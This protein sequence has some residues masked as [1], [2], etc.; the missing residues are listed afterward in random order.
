MRRSNLGAKS[1]KL[2]PTSAASRGA[3]AVGEQINMVNK[4]EKFTCEL[5][6]W[7]KEYNRLANDDALL[8]RH[9]LAHDEGI[10]DYDVLMGYMRYIARI[11]KR[12]DKARA[13]ILAGH[14]RKYGR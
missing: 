7:I 13:K 5:N 8:K 1:A 4:L 6:A 10:Y 11:I 12:L 3:G 9:I 14:K 2:P